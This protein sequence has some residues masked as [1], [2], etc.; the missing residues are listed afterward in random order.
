MLKRYLELN[1]PLRVQLIRFLGNIPP[2]RD[3]IVYV[4]GNFLIV[5]KDENDD[6]PTWYNMDR[7]ECLEGVKPIETRQKARITTF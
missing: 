6:A 4:A 7:V 1:K 5:A 2:E 3:R